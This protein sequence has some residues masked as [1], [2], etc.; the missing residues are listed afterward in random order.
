MNKQII[1]GSALLLLVFGSAFGQEG[2]GRGFS[3]LDR[4]QRFNNTDFVFDISASRPTSTGT[5]GIGQACAVD[6]LP[7]LAGLGVSFVIFHIDPCAINLPHVHPRGTELFFVIQG[8][9]KTSFTEE[10]TGRTITNVVS[11]GQITV[12]PQ[13]LL[14]EEQ[15]NDCEPAIFISAFSSE[16]P[17]VLQVVNRL[18]TFPQEALTST[19]ATVNATIDATRDRLPVNP[20]VGTPE[21]L[22]R[23][24]RLRRNNRRTTTT[25]N[26]V[27]SRSG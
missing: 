10:N 2:G 26:P 17:G 23:C 15:N 20:A 8:R 4:R 18:F 24:A 1:V 13:G 9:F 5:G 16:D 21:C 3:A 6:N 12:F 19:F 11:A 25:P 22:A 7:P 14:H 27:F